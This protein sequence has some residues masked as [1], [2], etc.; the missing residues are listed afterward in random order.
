VGSS[1]KSRILIVGAGGHGKVVLDAVLSAD[2]L[3][4]IGFVD[5]DR[6]KWGSKILGFPVMGP[7]EHLEAM[8]QENGADG[9][10]IAIGDNY[11]REL[12]FRSVFRRGVEVF[13]VVH[14]TACL[15]RFVQMGKGVVILAGAVVNAGTTIADNVC[16]NTRASIDHDNR[17]SYSCHVF[18]NAT[19]AGNVSIGEFSY[20]GS[21]AVVIP[22]KTIGR[23]AY[24]GAGAV[25][26]ED[27]AEG[28]KVVGVPAKMI[29]SQLARPLSV[30]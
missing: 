13:G 3:E 30:K 2:K 24:C 23:F 14:P 21:A 29:G 8:V 10:V 16:V 6:Q 17:L 9:C 12:F 4:V 15:S 26:L 28:T 20:V 18:P 22:G 1:G 25:I 11:I 5:D 7:S 27:V 19:L